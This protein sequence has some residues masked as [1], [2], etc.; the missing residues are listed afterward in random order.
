MDRL[1]AGRFRHDV[2]LPRRTWVGLFPVEEIEAVPGGVR[3]VVR[4][5]GF[6]GQEGYVYYENGVAPGHDYLNRDREPLSGY[7]FKWRGGLNWW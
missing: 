5:S 6:L 4:G 7:W 3:F 2:A 1:A